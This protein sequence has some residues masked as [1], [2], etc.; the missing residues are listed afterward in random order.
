MKRKDHRGRAF[1]INIIVTV[2]I[3]ALVYEYDHKNAT[4]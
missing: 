3:A 4:C 2:G 1:C